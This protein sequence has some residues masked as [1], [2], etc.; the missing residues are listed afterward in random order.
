MARWICV[1]ILQIT[2]TSTVPEH[3]WSLFFFFKST[4]PIR[5]ELG[6]NQA[7]RFSGVVFFVIKCM[8]IWGL[9]GDPVILVVT[10]VAFEERKSHY[11]SVFCPLLSPL[12]VSSVGWTK[13]PF[14]QQRISPKTTVLSY[15]GKQS[16]FKNMLRKFCSGPNK[17]Y[18]FPYSSLNYATGRICF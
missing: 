11:F 7:N 2:T 14:A 9:A 18:S 10:S 8:I 3:H 15:F 12:C 1:R 6:W 16:A 13:R 4:K 17:I 5:T